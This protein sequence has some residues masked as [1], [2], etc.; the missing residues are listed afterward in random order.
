MPHSLL[1]D[2]SMQAWSDFGNF[3]LCRIISRFVQKR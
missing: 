2:T 1:Q 3:R